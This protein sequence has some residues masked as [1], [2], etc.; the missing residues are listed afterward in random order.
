LASPQIRKLNNLYNSN[1]ALTDE[2]AGLRLDV[3]KGLKR[4]EKATR[5]LDKTKKAEEVGDWRKV[6]N[7]TD[8][9]FRPLVLN[10]FE[11]AIKKLDIIG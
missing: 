7:P 5:E 8:E 6:E 3:K 1:L 9:T 11:S 10:E 2:V 4:I